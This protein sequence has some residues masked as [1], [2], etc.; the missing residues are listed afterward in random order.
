VTSLARAFGAIWVGTFDGGLSRLEGGRV[1]ALPDATRRWGVDRRINDLAV[2]RDTRGRE[3]LWVATDRGLYYHDGRVFSPVEEAGAPGRVHVTSLHVDDAGALWVTSARLLSRLREGRWQSWG[4]DDR[5]PV[6]QLHSVVTDATGAVW[7]GSLHGLFRLDPE[8]GAFTRHTV[9]SGALPVDWV[10]ALSRWEGGVVAGTYHGGRSWYEAGRFRIEGEGVGGLPA[11][12]V[13]P[14]AMRALGGRLWVGT[15]E[16]GLL[17]GRPGRWSRLR[18]GD[19]LPSDD[20][21]DV[22]PAPEGGAWIAT[23]GGLARV[24]E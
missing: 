19:G 6:M 13:N 12:W 20:V 14:H 7:V 16:R 15:M 18:V 10:T 9:S 4:G 21:T 23:R 24:V 1:V 22:L 17:V 2:T 3:R 5:F 8:T 11:G